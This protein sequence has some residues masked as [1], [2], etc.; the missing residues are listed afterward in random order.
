MED[1]LLVWLVILTDS[2]QDFTF[3]YLNITETDESYD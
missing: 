3:S 1:S 2:Y